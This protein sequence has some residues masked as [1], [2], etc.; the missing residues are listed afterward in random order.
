MNCGSFFLDRIRDGMT[1][2]AIQF[3]RA[4]CSLRL[5]SRASNFPGDDSRFQPITQFESAELANVIHVLQD[6][7]ALVLS[8]QAP[9]ALK[10]GLHVI[11]SLDYRLKYFLQQF[12]SDKIPR[13]TASSFADFL[14]CIHSF[15]GSRDKRDMA[16]TDKS[17][18][19]GPLMSHLFRVLGK[20]L[21]D[22]DLDWRTAAEIVDITAAVARKLPNEEKHY[23]HD[24]AFDAIALKESIYACCSVFPPTQGWLDVILSATS[25]AVD[26]SREPVAREASLNEKGWVGTALEYFNRNTA[27]WDEHIVAGVSGLLQASLYYGVSPQTSS[28]HLILRALSTPG[29]ISTTAFWVMTDWRARTWFQDHGVQQIL[30]QHSIWTLLGRVVINNPEDFRVRRRYFEIGDFLAS[31]GGWELSIR[32]ELSTWITVFFRPGFTSGQYPATEFNSVLCSIW[33][34]DSGTRYQF[35]DS[36]EKALGSTLTLLASVWRE[37]EFNSSQIG[38]NFIPFL[39]STVSA[40]LRVTHARIPNPTRP[41]SPDFRAIFYV[42]LE[43]ALLQATAKAEVAAAEHNLGIPEATSVEWKEVLDGTVK[44]LADLANTMPSDSGDFSVQ[45]SL[46]DPKNPRELQTDWESSQAA[47]T[48]KIDAL[49]QIIQRFFFHLPP[50]KIF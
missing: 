33:N 47:F 24:H 22:N 8:Y 7:P 6:F 42:P 50:K 32:S 26:T 3:G 13:L 40:A 43:Q 1:Q 12:R 9:L 36:G 44:I 20:M 37:F 4:Y 18:S 15:L 11:P 46:R 34:A 45:R 29:D 19:Q 28:I 23:L 27:E 21:Q 17:H 5:V 25:L 10:W 41:I 38:D 49:D 2:R 31:T 35:A 48:E 14:F 30:Q 16:R 39:R